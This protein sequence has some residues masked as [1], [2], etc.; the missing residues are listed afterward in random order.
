MMQCPW[1]RKETAVPLHFP[2]PFLSICRLHTSQS[3]KFIQVSVRG[4]HDQKVLLKKPQLVCQVDGLLL[5][6]LNPNDEQV[7]VSSF[8]DILKTTYNFSD[9]LYLL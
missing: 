1:S 7:L 2:P 3:R 9:V 6:D 4:L 8:I 5:R